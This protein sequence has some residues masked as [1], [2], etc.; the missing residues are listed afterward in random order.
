MWIEKWVEFCENV[1]KETVTFYL[2]KS[3]LKPKQEDS[4]I[5]RLEWGRFLQCNYSKP[6]SWACHAHS[7]VPRLTHLCHPE[8]IQGNRVWVNLHPKTQGILPKE[9]FFQFHKIWTSKKIVYT[10]QQIDKKWTWQWEIVKPKTKIG[11]SQRN[12]GGTKKV[13]KCPYDI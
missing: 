13:E 6:K 9:T 5:P 7:A 12:L 10:F 4:L 2:T 11:N 8:K 1:F 3:L